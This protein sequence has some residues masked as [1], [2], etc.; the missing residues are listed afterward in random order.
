M[1]GYVFHTFLSMWYLVNGVVPC[2]VNLLILE[3]VQTEFKMVTKGCWL[4]SYSNH[5]DVSVS[6]YQYM[7]KG[8]N[9]SSYQNLSVFMTSLVKS[10]H[11]HLLHIYLILM[12]ES[13]DSKQIKGGTGIRDKLRPFDFLY[14]MYNKGFYKSQLNC[15]NIV[16]TPTHLAS[17]FYI[18]LI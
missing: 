9:L 14:V 4:E 10:W 6:W 3:Q 13:N 1:N 16:N 11:I 17:C 5:Q 8:S 2:I 15:Y 12:A 7:A 18:F